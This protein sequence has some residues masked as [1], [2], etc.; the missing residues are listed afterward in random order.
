MKKTLLLSAVALMAS[1]AMAQVSEPT[2][3]PAWENTTD[4]PGDAN[5]RYAVGVNGKMYIPHYTNSNIVCLDKNGKTTIETGT[6]GWCIT[7]D[8]AGNLLIQTNLW[9][10][11]SNEWAILPAGKT[12]KADLIDLGTIASPNGTEAGSMHTVGRAIGNVMSATGGAFY[13]MGNKQKKITKF[14]IANGTVVNEKCTA[15]E[16]GGSNE[17][18]ANS[19][20]IVQPINNDVNATDNVVWTIRSTANQFFKLDGTA[21]KEYA[22]TETGASC[23]TGGGDIITLGGVIYTIEPSGTNYSDGFVIVD[24]T[25]DKV[26]YTREKTKVNPF[27]TSVTQAYVGFEMTSATTA[28]IYHFS[29]GVVAS[30]YTFEVPNNDPTAIEV[31]EAEN[32]PVE[33]YNLQGVKVANP[34]K[35]LFIKKQGNKATKV[36]M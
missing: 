26:V 7:A 2:L 35:G 22:K 24:R 18:I 6:K 21:Y 20:A 5:A 33:Y 27:G 23:G 25:N 29:P 10:S 8:E 11:S 13:V 4:L 30:M 14:F 17:Y 28:N 31:I 1:T 34:E 36:I 19:Q 9:G 32:A 15:I 16:I 3:T 12:A